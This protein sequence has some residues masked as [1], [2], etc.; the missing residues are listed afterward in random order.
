MNIDNLGILPV[1]G[2]NLVLELKGCAVI[3]L[4]ITGLCERGRSNLVAI[5]VVAKFTG[6]GT[7]LTNGTVACAI[8]S[9][10][11]N[12]IGDNTVIGIFG[13]P[14]YILKVYILVFIGTITIQG[15]ELFNL[16][17]NFFTLSGLGNLDFCT[18]HASLHGDVSAA[19]EAVGVVR[20]LEGHLGGAGAFLFRDLKP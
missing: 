9:D 18:V 16:A 19:V 1:V 12:A 3:Y 14:P 10:E 4:N 20:S 7:F 2:V 8:N 11:G 6:D 5:T 15:Q 13:Y 17:V